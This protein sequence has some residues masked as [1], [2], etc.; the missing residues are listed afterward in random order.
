MIATSDETAEALERLNG[1]YIYFDAQKLWEDYKKKTSFKAQLASVAK[2]IRQGAF[3]EE[4]SLNQQLKRNRLKVGSLN[5]AMHLAHD[6]QLKRHIAGH[7]S[8]TDWERLGSYGFFSN[9]SPY[10]KLYLHDVQLKETYEATKR[11][12]KESN[13]KHQKADD[14]A[15][16]LNRRVGKRRMTR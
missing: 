8:E 2:N 4:P 1:N 7:L 14:R 3:N 16:N 12:R 10:M 6:G 13:L 15:R 11:D 5:F 9:N